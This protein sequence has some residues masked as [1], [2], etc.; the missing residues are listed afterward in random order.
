MNKSTHKN[1]KIKDGIIL[2]AGSGRR[3]GYLGNLL[4]KTLFPVYDKPIL[5]HIINFLENFE[6]E[7]IYIVVNF[8]KEKIIEYIKDIK[9]F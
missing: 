8:H 1:N 2:A 3:L 7:N 4:P 5:N 6:V 9:S